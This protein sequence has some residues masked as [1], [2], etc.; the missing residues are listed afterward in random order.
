MPE[1][2]EVNT[3]Q[4]IFDEA[5]LHQ[6]IQRVD[7]YDAQIIKNVSGAE[8]SDLLFKQTFKSSYRQGKYLF[9]ILTSGHSVMMHFGMT[10]DFK[11]YNDPDERAKHERF[12]F[13]FENGFHLGFD[14]PRKF[15]K[16]LYLEDYK[17]YL[18][19]INLGDDALRIKA[20]TFLNQM[21]GKT[22]TIKGFLLKQSN[23]AGVGNLYA[24][25]ICFRTK[26]HPASKIPKLKTAKRKAIFHA[27]KKI[28]Q[29]G[30]DRNATYGNYP[31]NWLWHFRNEGEKGPK[32]KGIIG[33]A[34][35]AGRTSYFVEGVQKLWV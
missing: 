24:D 21:T 29:Y 18:K 4:Q 6:K 7:I 16:I 26:I 9:G 27:M 15:A 34:T 1:L 22:G 19:K 14:C 13:V 32:G 17:A 30:V 12:V 33:R 23:L 20:E 2:P 25:E 11:Y 3:F 10:G 31:D 5:A 35:I 28:L 8:F